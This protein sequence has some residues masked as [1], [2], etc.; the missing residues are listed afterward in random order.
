MAHSNV[1]FGKHALT[2]LSISIMTV[3]KNVQA[4]PFNVSEKTNW[5]FIKVTTNDNRH[6]WGEASLNGWEPMLSAATV[7]HGE[8]IVDLS[9]ADALKRLSASPLLPGGL[10]SNAVISALMQALWTLQASLAEQPLY[11]ALGGK[12]RDAVA[13]YANINRATRDR[14]P[15]GFAATASKAAS[16][17]F[18]A[19]KAAPFDGV[20]PASCESGTALAA[21][22]HGIDC[23]YAIRDAVGP[24]ALLMVDCHWRFNEAAALD[25]LRALQA[26][27]LH[28]FECPLAETYQHWAPLRNVRKKANDMGI[29]IAAAETQVGLASF[30]M[31][32]KEKLVDVIMPDIKYCGGPVTMKAIA[33]A[34]GAQGVLFAPHNPTGPICTIASLHVACAA[35]QAHMLELQFDESPLYDSLIGHKHPKLQNSAF[36]PTQDAGLGVDLDASLLHAHPWARVPFGIETLL[37]A[38]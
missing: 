24:D 12:Q 13:A 17:G 21:L 25:V 6:A 15:A 18:T 27:G 19:F 35:D 31:L 36:A 8:Q 37:A 11:G 32:I 14:S 26:V 29:L 28:W 5:F 10:V 9:V 30:D 1:A 22:R 23:L 7:F 2:H 34:A 4:V 33:D 38:Q 20:T 16:Q 3:I